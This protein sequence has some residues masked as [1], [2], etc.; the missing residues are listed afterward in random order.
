M[1]GAR[2][3]PDKVALF[4]RN[5]PDQFLPAPLADHLHKLGPVFCIM[6]DDQAGILVT[7]QHIPA[8]TLPQGTVLMNAGI[9]IVGVHLNAQ[10]CSGVND[11]HQQREPV[12]PGVAKKLR[13]L[14][15]QC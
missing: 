2:F 5:L 1:H 8:F 4:H 12:Q 11:L 9:D 3:D 10:V 13:V 6:A 15:P 14:L 7:G